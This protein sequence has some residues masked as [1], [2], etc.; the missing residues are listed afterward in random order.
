MSEPFDWGILDRHL[1]GEAT[2]EEEAELRQ[3]LAA[4]PRRAAMLDETRRVLASRPTS[5]DVDAAWKAMAR[6]LNEPVLPL[7]LA[8][9]RRAARWSRPAWAVRIAALI[10]IALGAVT[11]WRLMVSAPSGT[12][13]VATRELSTVRG[14]R[15]ELRMPD[16][17]RVVLAAE[18]R[19]TYPAEASPG[20]RTVALSGE[21]YFEVAPDSTR[22]FVVRTSGAVTR[23]LGTEFT[24]RAYG[25][26]AEVEVAVAGGRVYLAPADS[27][28]RA[29]SSGV[30]LARGQLGTLRGG[31]LS[32]R[33]IDDLTPFVG[34]T[35]GQLAFD[36]TPLGEALARLERWY[37]VEL[38]VADSALAARRL[39]ARFRAESLDDAL[40][41]IALALD[42]R[43]ERAGR[44]I[45]FRPR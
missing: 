22:P 37:D 19:L 27:A 7:S 2:P 14:Q 30:V 29:D 17:T 1:A 21:A 34:W 33:A 13:P 12:A 23:V 6:R 31:R 11:V 45:T 3:W 38:V 10:L 42:A 4:D 18:S 43:H 15:A 8:S 5:W 44:T 24:V 41:A 25:A 36:G 20:E 32:V 35:E 9:A 39:S 16:G 40:D 26:G 28:V